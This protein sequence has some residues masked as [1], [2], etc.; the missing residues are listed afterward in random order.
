MSHIT[1][2]QDAIN[3]LHKAKATHVESVPVREAHQGRT[4]WEGVVEVFRL[5][6]HPNDQPDLRLGTRH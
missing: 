2:L 1:E 6:G 5:R 3:K 4:I